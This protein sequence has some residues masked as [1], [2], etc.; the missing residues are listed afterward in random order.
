MM[1]QHVLELCPKEPGINT[2]LQNDILVS[3]TQA[4]DWNQDL[5][6]QGYSIMADPNPL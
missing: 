6:S 5:T 4:Y 3:S 1:I 2:I